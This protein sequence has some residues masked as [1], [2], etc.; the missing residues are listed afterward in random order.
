VIVRIQKKSVDVL[1]QDCKTRSCFTLGADKGTFVAGRGYTSYHKE[2]RWVCW[3]R[4]TQGCPSTGTCPQ[5]QTALVEGQTECTTCKEQA[6]WKH[7]R[8][9]QGN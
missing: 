3:R 1:D 2:Q 6:K 9:P 7:P 5:C 8:P 4:H